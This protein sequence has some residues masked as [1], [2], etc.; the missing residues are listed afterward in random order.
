M[1]CDQCKMNIATTHI[2]SSVNGVVVEKNLCSSCA[3][4]SGYSQFSQ[5]GLVNMLAGLFGD[6]YSIDSSKPNM[7][8]QCCKA[9]F[10]DIAQTGKMGC[11]NC[12]TIF[13]EQLF[14]SLQR[15]HGKTKH[16]GKIP[17]N[18]PSE[19]RIKSKLE[20]LKSDLKRAV[21]EEKFEQ[22]AKLR[23]EIKQLETDDNI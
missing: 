5:N 7:R 1:L 15:L 23:D 16:I 21:S 9:A 6:S 19:I 12:Y 14:P 8:C 18:A 20:Q 10:S 3:A 4:Q 2:R 11:S 17:A 13:S 22:A